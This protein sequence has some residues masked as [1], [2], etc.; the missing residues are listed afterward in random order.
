MNY[1][2]SVFADKTS[3]RPRVHYG[4]PWWRGEGGG[5]TPLNLAP[6]RR[7]VNCIDYT[8]QCRRENLQGLVQVIF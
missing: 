4:A 1:Q 8:P 3:F 6:V 5:D 7:I 2:F